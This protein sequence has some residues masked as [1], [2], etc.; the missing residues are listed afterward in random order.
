MYCRWLDRA[1]RWYVER[2]VSRI[3]PERVIR[4]YARA[5]WRADTPDRRRMAPAAL[6]EAVATRI[7]RRWRR[8][9]WAYAA[10]SAAAG[11]FGPLV[12]WPALLAATYAWAAE[13]AYVYGLDPHDDARLECLRA[14]LGGALTFRVGVRRWQGLAG[15]GR[16][17]LKLVG[18]DLRWLVWW[19]RGLILAALAG[20]GPEM[21][22][23]DRAIA[24]VRSAWRDEAE[25]GGI[26]CS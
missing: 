16:A 8:L 24:R 6:R 11:V 2:A 4:E 26:G 9:I 1:G 15:V 18:Y 17:G 7:G 14:H 23:A 10:G 22:L 20:Q 12:G 19:D 5:G 13:L 21:A 3:G 25:D